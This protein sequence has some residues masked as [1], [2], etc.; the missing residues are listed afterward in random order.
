[1]NKRIVN[2]IGAIV[3]ITAV[4]AAMILLNPDQG[5]NRN[6]PSTIIS[7]SDLRE[8]VDDWMSNPDDD[9][10]RQRL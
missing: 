10:R 7:Q 1:M 2:Y 3:A 4:F 9:D 8:M 5:I 6:E